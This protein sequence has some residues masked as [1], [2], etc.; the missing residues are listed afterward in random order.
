MTLKVC[1]THKTGYGIEFKLED[2]KVSYFVPPTIVNY[3]DMDRSVDLY[4]CRSKQ[5]LKLFELV[6]TYQVNNDTVQ[7]MNLVQKLLDDPS[8]ITAI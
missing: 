7:M 4:R 6:R 2:T 8:Y 5:Y 1:G 3:P